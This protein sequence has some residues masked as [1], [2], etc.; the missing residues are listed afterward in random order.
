MEFSISGHLAF[1]AHMSMSY[2]YYS[3]ISTYQTYFNSLLK[4][5]SEETKLCAL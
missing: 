3:K 1:R 5:L 4:E 2:L